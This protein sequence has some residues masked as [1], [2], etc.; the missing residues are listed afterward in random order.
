MLY[1]IL[2][3]L[4][5]VRSSE[6]FEGGDE[7]DAHLTD[8]INHVKATNLLHPSYD[9]LVFQNDLETFEKVRNIQHKRATDKRNQSVVPML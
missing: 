9:D 8:L 3:V 6:N 1:F 7:E 5:S 4:S 2:P